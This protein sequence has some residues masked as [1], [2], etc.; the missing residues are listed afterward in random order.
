MKKIALSLST[1]ILALATSLVNAQVTSAQKESDINKGVSERITCTFDGKTPNN[2]CLAAMRRA[3][4]ADIDNLQ[5]YEK[6]KK[7]TLPKD[8]LKPEDQ[9][10]K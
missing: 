7:S 1:V 6:S 8:S 4:V 10:L 3:I 2:Q 5:S 9:K